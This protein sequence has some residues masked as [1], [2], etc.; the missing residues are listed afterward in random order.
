MALY[1]GKFY[2][3]IT[4]IVK[5]NSRHLTVMVTGGTSRPDPIMKLSRSSNGAYRTPLI[6]ILVFRVLVQVGVQ[7]AS[8]PVCQC[9]I[10]RLNGF[11]ISPKLFRVTALPTCHPWE[12]WGQFVVTGV[13]GGR[14][15]VEFRMFL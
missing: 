1:I 11:Q 14:Q 8:V 9:Q 5:K 10:Q 2:V 4:V 15:F 3:T 13:G 12:D 6:Y 7:P